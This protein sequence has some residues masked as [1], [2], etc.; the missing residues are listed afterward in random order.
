MIFGPILTAKDVIRIL[1]KL[2]FVEIRQ[3][4]SHK[5]FR[6]NDGRQTTVQCH[7]GRD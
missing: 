5:Q 3:K 6:H 4:G 7:Q 1:G 2:G